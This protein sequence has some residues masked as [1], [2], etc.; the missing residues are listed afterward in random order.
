MLTYNY[1]L[2]SD[3]ETCSQFSKCN[4]MLK[5]LQVQTSIWFVGYTWVTFSYEAFHV[6]KGKHI[7]SISDDMLL[8]VFVP[9]SY[10]IWWW[11]KY[12]ICQIKCAKCLLFWIFCSCQWPDKTNSRW[13]YTLQCPWNSWV[14]CPIHIHYMPSRSCCNTWYK[15]T[16]LGYDCKESKEIFHIWDSSAGW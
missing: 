6:L 2:N 8:L 15:A 7:W 11:H 10:L 14:K 9:L 16:V 3:Y 1:H 5:L 12:L 4:L 13:R